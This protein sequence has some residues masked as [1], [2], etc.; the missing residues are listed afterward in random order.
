MSPQEMRVKS[1]N[2]YELQSILDDILRIFD[3]KYDDIYK[4]FSKYHIYELLGE[5]FSQV[6]IS[7]SDFTEIVNKISKIDLYPY[8]IGIPILKITKSK[9]ILPLIPLGNILTKFCKKIIRL[10]EKLVNKLI[11][12]KS[13]FIN[14]KITFD[15]AII[16]NKY[17]EFIAY[18]KVKR[19]KNGTLIIPELDI[20][21]YLREGG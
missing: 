6:S 10:D 1:L 12:G 3:C 17:G 11:Y 16:V 7:T 20:G 15:R 21:W 4:Y 2:I 8:F 18:V 5:K 9:N 14:E 13:V 19:F